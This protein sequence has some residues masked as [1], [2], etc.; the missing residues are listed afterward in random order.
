MILSIDRDH[1]FP[2]ATGG[3]PCCD[4]YAW[5]GPGGCTCWEP[6]Y[7][8]EQCEPVLG[9]VVARRSPCADCAY[10][11]GSPERTGAEGYSGDAEELEHLAATGTPFWCHQGMRRIVRWRHPS[12]MVVDAHPD[13]YK[14][15]IVTRPDGQPVALK[16]DGSPAHLCGGW[17]AKKEKY[18]RI[19]GT[20][21]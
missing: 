10:R 16:A 9:V 2:D 14:P 20:Q 19:R 12:G 3:V 8:Q 13:S 18:D 6:E 1:D 15:P 21:S 7:D 4:G 5:R 11:K 17:R